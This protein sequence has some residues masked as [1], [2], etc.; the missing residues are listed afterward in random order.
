MDAPATWSSTRPGKVVESEDEVSLAAVPPAVRA[1]LEAS[2]KVMKVEALTKGATTYEAQVEKNGKKAEVT[3][4][5]A[6]KRIKN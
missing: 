2:G 4:D 5:A 1:T 6:G 3:V